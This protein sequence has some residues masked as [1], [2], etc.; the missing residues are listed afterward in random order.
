MRNK[1]RNDNYV[2]AKINNI[3]DSIP[4]NPFIGFSSTVRNN[5]Y[6]EAWDEFKY[7]EESSEYRREK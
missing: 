1:R 2:T 7:S 3:I 6:Y 4:T 5:Q